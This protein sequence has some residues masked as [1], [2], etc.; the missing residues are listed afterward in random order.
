MTWGI[1]I[2]S[3]NIIVPSC[4]SVDK[5]IIFFISHSAKALRP[6]IR[7]VKQAAGRRITFSL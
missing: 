6:A 3:L 5:A 2:A 4:L 1:P 7:A